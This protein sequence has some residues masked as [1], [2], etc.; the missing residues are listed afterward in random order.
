M[1]R[2]YHGAS[3]LQRVDPP[4]VRVFGPAAAPSVLGH[5]VLQGFGRQSRGDRDPRVPRG[6][7]NGRGRFIRCGKDTGLAKWPSHSFA[8]NTAWI[9]AAAIA[10][11]QLCWTRLL[12]LDGPLARAER[13]T[14]RYRL[15]H[16]AARFVRHARRLI[17]RIPETWPWVPQGPAGDADRDRDQRPARCGLQR[18][19]A[20]P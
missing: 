14:L 17:L 20:Q 15:L 3:R 12:L 7:R 2:P 13:V 5:Y 18:P 4:A 11:D 10:I 6:L 16:A 19:A 1:D 9:T 8:I